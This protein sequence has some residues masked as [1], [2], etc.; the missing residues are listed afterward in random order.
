MNYSFKSL[1]HA[2]AF[3]AP[4]WPAS[5]AH[6]ILIRGGRP[7]AAPALAAAAHSAASPT[8]PRARRRPII[9]H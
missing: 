6:Q 2:S 9:L 1:Q 4:E 5:R 3:Y 7:I 8:L